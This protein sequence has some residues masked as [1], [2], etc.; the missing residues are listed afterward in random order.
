MTPFVWSVIYVA[1]LGVLSHIIGQALPRRWFN[2]DRFP[3]SS[4]RWEQGGRIYETWF[5]IRAWKDKMPDMSRVMKDMLPKRLPQGAGEQDIGALVA[6]TCVAELVHV[7]LCLFAPGIYTFWDNRNG[8]L[9]T[10]FYIFCNIPFI[11]IQRYVRPQLTVLADRMRAREAH[12]R[13]AETEDA[14]YAQT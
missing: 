6:E 14:T 7:V 8:V 4:F 9:L 13:A 10:L 2:A 3:F 1:L 5:G 11:L 12:R